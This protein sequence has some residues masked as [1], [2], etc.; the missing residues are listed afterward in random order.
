MKK[1]IDRHGPPLHEVLW[2]LDNELDKNPYSEIGVGVSPWDE[3]YGIRSSY[4]FIKLS[5]NFEHCIQDPNI[6]DDSVLVG[7]YAHG[8]KKYPVFLK[9][10]VE[11]DEF[12]FV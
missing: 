2:T 9:T 6:S 7:H 8:D 3:I 11:P 1:K 10:T 4:T 12:E 5:K